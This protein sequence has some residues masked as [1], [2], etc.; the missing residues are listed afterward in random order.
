M[1]KK[2]EQEAKTALELVRNHGINSGLVNIRALW[3]GVPK[4]YFN[5]SDIDEAQEI[6]WSNREKNLSHLDKV[7]RQISLLAKNA[8]PYGPLHG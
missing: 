1:V 4:G 6:Y 3:S 8:T 2:L 7:S 5:E